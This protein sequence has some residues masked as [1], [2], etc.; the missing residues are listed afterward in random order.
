MYSLLSSQLRREAELRVQE[1]SEQAL[2]TEKEYEDFKRR[3]T[4]RGTKRIRAA[5]NT[6]G[7]Q[8]EALTDDELDVIVKG[9]AFA[10]MHFAYLQDPKLVLS[11]DEELEEESH[12]QKALSAYI[13]LLPET[14]KDQYYSLKVINLVSLMFYI[15]YIKQLTHIY[16]SILHSSFAE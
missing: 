16:L 1:V 4:T 15:A 9:K 14:L 7:K 3:L 12:E 2:V 10:V 11:A 13:L 5:P 8:L 6:R